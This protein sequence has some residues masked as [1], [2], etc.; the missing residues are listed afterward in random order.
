MLSANDVGKSLGAGSHHAREFAWQK[1]H[2]VLKPSGKRALGIRNVWQALGK[3]F[4][5]SFRVDHDTKGF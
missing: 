5:Q 1:E 2:R 3:G 4:L